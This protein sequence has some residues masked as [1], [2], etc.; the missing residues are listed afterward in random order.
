[1]TVSAYTDKTKKKLIGQTQIATWSGGDEYAQGEETWVD[2]NYQRQ[3]I[4]TTMYTLVNKL[5]FRIEPNPSTQSPDGTR[6][7]T[8][9]EKN[10]LVNKFRTQHRSDIEAK[11]QEHNL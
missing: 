7:W 3:G 8:G 11:R 4:A 5:G 9:W 6:M 2:K 1:M 10:G